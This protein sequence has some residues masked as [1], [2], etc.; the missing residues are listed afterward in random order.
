MTIPTT[1]RAAA[2]MAS[3]ARTIAVIDGG[4]RTARA[5]ALQLHGLACERAVANAAA[6]HTIDRSESTSAD[7]PGGGRASGSALRSVRIEPDSSGVSSDRFR[8]QC[9]RSV[10]FRSCPERKSVMSFLVIVAP[11]I[12]GAAVPAISPNSSW[13]AGK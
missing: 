7:L 2:A 3:V 9:R 5:Q 12:L 1:T 8:P 13:V 4:N 11:S 10:P 6:G